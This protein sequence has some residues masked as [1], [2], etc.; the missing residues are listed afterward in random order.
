MR[1][2]LAVIVVAFGAAAPA[3]S[4]PVHFIVDVY[5]YFQ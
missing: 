1:R 5:G 2:W 3:S 4:A